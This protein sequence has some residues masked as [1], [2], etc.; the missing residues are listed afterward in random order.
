MT[1]CSVYFNENVPH[2]VKSNSLL[3]LS[4]YISYYI[5]DPPTL[6]SPSVCSARL[7]RPQWITSYGVT[8]AASSPLTLVTYPCS[9][10]CWSLCPHCW[11][12]WSTKWWSYTR[13]GMKTDTGGTKTT[14]KAA[15]DSYIVME[16]GILQMGWTHCP[17]DLVLREI[18]SQ[19]LLKKQE[20]TTSQINLSGKA[21]WASLDYWGLFSDHINPLLSLILCRTWMCFEAGKM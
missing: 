19:Q 20:N 11:W 15:L 16:R 1:C 21:A 18:L 4:V 13:Y 8:R 9:H 10:G 5:T 3:S 17:S 6:F 14:K 2:A 7:F 12:W